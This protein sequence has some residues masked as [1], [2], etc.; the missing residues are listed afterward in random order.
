MPFDTEIHVNGETLPVHVPIRYTVEDVNAE[1]LA[2]DAEGT[3]VLF[4][5]QHGKGKIFFSLYPLEA[6]AAAR[7]GVFYKEGMPRYDQVYRMLA[8]AAGAER[9]VDTDSPFVR[10]TE[11]KIDDNKRYVVLINYSQSPQKANVFVS[12]GKLTSV[13][14]S[15]IEDGVLCLRE[16]DAAIFMYEKGEFPC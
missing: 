5:K 13:Y 2:R 7:S 15:E 10:A 16:H 12:G 3:P 6:D 14:G 1:V 9:A 4:M 8:D 11:H